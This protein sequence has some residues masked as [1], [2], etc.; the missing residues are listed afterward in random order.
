MNES[1]SKAHWTWQNKWSTLF[2]KAHN[3]GVLSPTLRQAELSA[4]EQDDLSSYLVLL[5]NLFIYL[6]VFCIKFQ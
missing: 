1:C 6:I 4:S 3:V 2:M 5:M